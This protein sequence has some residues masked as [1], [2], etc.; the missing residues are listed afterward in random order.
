[1]PIK[2]NINELL[3]VCGV[4][5]NTHTHTYTQRH[6]DLYIHAHRATFEFISRKNTQEWNGQ[7]YAAVRSKQHMLLGNQEATLP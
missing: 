4:S 7:N 2:S 6:V 1:M 3:S 5:P